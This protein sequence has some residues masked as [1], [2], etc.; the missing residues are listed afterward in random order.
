MP[1]TVTLK[2]THGYPPSLVQMHGVFFAWGAGIRPGEVKR[3]DQIDIH[4]TVMTLLG[5]QP[6]RSVDGHAIAAVSAP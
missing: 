2:A 1:P 4:P 5:L 3:L 6:G